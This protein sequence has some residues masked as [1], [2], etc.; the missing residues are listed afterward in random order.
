MNL[1]GGT[2]NGA[3][4]RRPLSE[5]IKPVF[6]LSKLQLSFGIVKT[7]MAKKDSVKVSNLGTD[8]LNVSAVSSTNQSFTFA[9]STMRIAPA[10]N[11]YL[12]INFAPQDTLNKTGFI[13]LKHNADGSPD[14]IVV[15]G[16]GLLTAIQDVTLIPTEYE[17]SQNYPNPFNPSTTISFSLPSRSFVSLKLFDVLGREVATIISEEMSAGIYTRQWNATGMPSGVYFYRLQA[18]SFIDTK[19]LV[20]L[21]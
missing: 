21:R 19:K 1:I 7:G 3:V 10:A 15:S 4:W 16:K 6:S 17:L 20:L 8:T 14:S 11:A 12:I 9:P 18:G 2:W 13:I 5:M